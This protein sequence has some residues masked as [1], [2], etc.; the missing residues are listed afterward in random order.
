MASSPALKRKLKRAA[1]RPSIGGDGKRVKSSAAP[2]FS[3]E[4]APQKADST[5]DKGDRAATGNSN[6]SAPQNG[7]SKPDKGDTAAVSNS[8]DGEVGDGQSHKSEVAASSSSQESASQKSDGESDKPA[9]EIAASSDRTQPHRARAPAPQPAKAS[10]RTKAKQAAKVDEVLMQKLKIP[11][12]WEYSSYADDD[13]LPETGGISEILEAAW[14]AWQNAGAEKDDPSAC[15]ELKTILPSSAHLY[16]MAQVA[17]DGTRNVMRR[18]VVNTTEMPQYIFRHPGWTSHKLNRG[19]NSQEFELPVES[20]EFRFVASQLPP[21]AR[22][23]KIVQHH[24]EFALRR[25]H[26]ALDLA[27][28][29]QQVQLLWHGT[30]GVDPQVIMCDGLDP[31]HARGGY[32]GNAA[33]LARDSAYCHEGSFAHILDRNL[34]AA[35]RTYVLLA[36]TANLGRIAFGGKDQNIFCELRAP[37][38]GYDSTMIE[39]DGRFIHG[40]YSVG[41][42]R[43]AYE[44]HYQMRT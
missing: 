1:E 11:T 33:Y 9:I 15:V 30:R 23:L 14:V 19:G 7:D 44:V 39:V 34:P 29:K 36:F 8:K 26:A 41:D 25:F 6:A 12:S 24:V 37:P 4:S 18:V 31:R 2:S 42:T 13:W 10:L 21:G 16:W 40:V 20:D 22:A 17:A 28:K 32:L 3:K 38:D 5:A 35:E 43:L 27:H